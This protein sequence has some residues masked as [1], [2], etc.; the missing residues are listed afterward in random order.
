MTLSRQRSIISAL[1]L[2]ITGSLAACQHNISK[3]IAPIIHAP[4]RALESDIEQIVSSLPRQAS[5]P[6]LVSAL[7]LAI[8]VIMETPSGRASDVYRAAEALSDQPNLVTATA[9]VYRSLPPRALDERL[10][11][12]TL[13]GNARRPDSREF[14]DSIISSPLPPASPVYLQLSPRQETEIKM[15]KA[16]HA[17]GYL[18]VPQSFEM[19]RSIAIDHPSRRI[20]SAAIDTYM[21]NRDD[22]SSAREEL[23]SLLP[24]EMHCEIDRPRFTASIST[25]VFNAQ[26]AEWLSRC[27]Q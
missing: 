8:P 2:L 14:L 19:L 4:D 25:Q 12:L 24:E 20:R 10:A 26:V 16:I 1:V 5:T 21:W 22:S 7:E 15:E 13:I 3:N 23:V 17:L 18:R 11:L 6:E 9:S 27:G